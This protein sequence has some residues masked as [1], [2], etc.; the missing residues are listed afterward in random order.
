MGVEFSNFCND[1]ILYME[2]LIITFRNV[3]YV[4][5]GWYILYIYKFSRTD[6]IKIT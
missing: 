5:Y 1:G 3:Y 2:N 4:K 6:E